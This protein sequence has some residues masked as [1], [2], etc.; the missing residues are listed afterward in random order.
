MGHTEGTSKQQPDDNGSPERRKVGLLTSPGLGEQLASDISD[1]LPDLLR[2]HIS[3]E[4]RWEVEVASDPLTGSNVAVD[5]ILDELAGKKSSS[6]WDYIVSLTDL[7][8]RQDHKIV[9]AR[10]GRKLD[11]AV[12]SVP[13]LGAI[14]VHQR[15]RNMIL[16]VMDDLYRDTLAEE[17]PARFVTG[18]QAQ[19]GYEEDEQGQTTSLRYTAPRIWGH[20]KLLAGMVYANRPWRLL[21]SFK[22]TVATAFATGGYGLIFTTLWQIGNVYGYPR[23][24]T[25]MFAAMS[26]LI[27]WIILAH[28][29]WERPR[30][31]VGRYLNMLYNAST[32][33]TIASGVVFS[34]VAIF[35]LLLLAATIYIPAGMLEST[36]GQEVTPINYVRIAWVTASVATIAGAIGAGLEDTDEVRNATFGWRQLL[37]WEEHQQNTDSDG[38]DTDPR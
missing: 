12:I 20:V 31:G 22:T 30:S 15:V 3:D 25:L 23:L 19:R 32:V 28:N 7:P 21:P 27:A 2:E 35:L 10:T 16:E 13:P 17:S 11:V 26:I 1:T 6:D 37:R 29:L 24:I 8:I 33:L 9:I 4:V 5:D 36:I 14:R 38:A 34:Y 18:R